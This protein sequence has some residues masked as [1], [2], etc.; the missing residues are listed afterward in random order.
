[1][2]TITLVRV[3]MA[4]RNAKI[5]ARP[6]RTMHHKTQIVTVLQSLIYRFIELKLIEDVLV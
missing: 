5:F 4:T 2:T 3:Q 6:L 1:M